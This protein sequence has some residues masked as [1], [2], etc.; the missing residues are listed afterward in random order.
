ME[1][2]Q[3][4]SPGIRISSISRAASNRTCLQGLALKPGGNALPHDQALSVTMLSVSCLLLETYIKSVYL[5]QPKRCP[6]GNGSHD[7]NGCAELP[8]LP[9]GRLQ[10][11]YAIQSTHLPVWSYDKKFRFRSTGDAAREW[12]AR[13]APRPG[14]DQRSAT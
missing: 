2:S 10:P 14:P 13:V 8:A 12:R 5:P 6:D 11:R 1:W 7:C 4:Y 3:P 9:T